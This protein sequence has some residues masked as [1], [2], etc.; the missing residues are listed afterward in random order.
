MTFATTLVSS[1]REQLEQWKLGAWT[2]CGEGVAGANGSKR[3]ATYWLEGLGINGLN[4]CVDQ[5][6]SAAFI[7]WCMRKAGMALGEFPF[8]AGHHTY[9]RWAINNAK[10]DKPGKSYYGRRIDVRQPRPGDLIAQWRKAKKTSPDPNITFDAQPDDFY[11]A[12]CDIVVEAG[13]E[14][15]LAIGGNV[16]NKVTLTRFTAIGGVLVPKKELICVMECAK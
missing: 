1:A 8:S 3:V 6:W 2:E 10:Q 7:C 12:H 13:S 11:P 16:S 9:I 5:A 4:G 15:I 14:A